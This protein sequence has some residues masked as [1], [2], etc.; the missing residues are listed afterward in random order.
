MI[1]RRTT[2]VLGAGASAAFKYPSGAGLRRQII[3]LHDKKVASV[4]GFSEDLV[5]LKEFSRAFKRSQMAS[6]DAFLARRPEFSEVGKRAIAAALLSIEDE[7]L[8]YN[9]DDDDNWY[10]YLFQELAAAT[11]NELDFS[12]LAIVTFNYD[13]SLEHYLFGALTNSYGK[14]DEEVLE[15]LSE[16]KVIHIYGSLGGVLPGMPDYIPYGNPPDRSAIEKA[17]KAIRVIPE[18][19]ADDAAL[20]DARNSLYMA[21]AICFLGFGYDETNLMLLK[22]GETCPA[23][24]GGNG[25]IG[26]KEKRRRAVVGTCYKMTL[27]EVRRVSYTLNNSYM[28]HSGK[29]LPDGFHDH[30]CLQ[31]LRETQILKKPW[32]K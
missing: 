18:G 3:E 29:T 31:T 21:E 14:S 32:S 1:K 26:E 23:F 2:L 6:I 24:V 15:K 7:G 10:P 12:K 9:T 13:R 22:A 17:A 16:L 19:R 5:D 20:G 25:V 4:A 30:K 27:E 11:W 8:L 28:H